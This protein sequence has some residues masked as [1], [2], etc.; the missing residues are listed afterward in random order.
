MIRLCTSA[1]LLH[2]AFLNATVTPQ[3]L[4]RIGGLTV[5][6]SPRYKKHWSRKVSAK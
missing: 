3:I 2:S 4:V 5:C 1:T 6:T